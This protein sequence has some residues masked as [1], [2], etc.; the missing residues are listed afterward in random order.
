[1]KPSKHPRRNITIMGLKVI[2]KV[3]N[4]EHFIITVNAGTIETSTNYGIT[5]D[6][7]AVRIKC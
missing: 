5:L 7:L 1:M 3:C 2:Q 4:Y 6:P